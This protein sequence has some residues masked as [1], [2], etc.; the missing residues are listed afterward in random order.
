MGAQCDLR[1]AVMASVADATAGAYSLEAE[2]RK[3]TTRCDRCGA[4]FHPGER[5][6]ITVYPNSSR[7]NRV[8]HADDA[9]PSAR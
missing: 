6:L 9:C 7:R 4:V 1:G 3:S 2:I 5:C 8:T